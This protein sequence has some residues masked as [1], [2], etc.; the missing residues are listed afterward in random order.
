MTAPSPSPPPPPSIDDGLTSAHLRTIESLLKRAP[1]PTERAMFSAMWSEHCAYVSSRMHLK[2]LPQKGACVI[3]GPGE[4]AGV[5]DIGE[6]LAC[7][8]KIESHNHPSFIEPY[9][10]AA[11]G[12]GGI[13]RD[14]F[15][16][17]ARPVAL[18]NALRFGAPTHPKTRS[19]LKGV[20]QG[21]AGYGNAIGIPTVGGECQFDDGYNHNN[22]VNVMA[23]GIASKK[24]IFYS[25]A[26]QD[27]ARVLYLGAP[28]GSD[29]IH[30]AT[31]ASAEFDDNAQQKRPTVQ[32]GDPFF[33]KRLM[34][35]CL[36][37]MADN[38]ILAIQDMGAAGLTSSISEM[39]D[40]GKSGMDIDLDTI[41]L[42]DA[43]MQ[44]QDIMLS[45]SQERM[46]LIA[47][48]EALDAIAAIAQAYRLPLVPIGHVNK[49]GTLTLRH[50][51]KIV[52]QLPVDALC[53][54][55][56]C[57]DLPQ[58]LVPAPT[59]TQPLP[60]NKTTIADDVRFLV[61]SHHSASRAWLYHQFDRHVGGNTV[62]KHVGTAALIVLPD[63]KRALALTVD[64]NQRY[65][66]LDPKLGAA[67]TVAQAW[68]KLCAI[69][70]D[71]LALT[72]NLN[73]ADPNNPHIMAQLS[74]A[75]DGI[76]LA[77]R[78]LNMPVVS[79]NVSL[80]N[81]TANQPIP[82][83]PIIG[84][85]GVLAS[86][87]TASALECW[88]DGQTIFLFSPNQPQLP[89]S[90]YSLAVHNRHEGPLP[91]LD[92]SLEKKH[93]EF[94]R[95]VVSSDTLACPLTNGGL[96]L[97]LAKMALASGVGFRLNK[98]LCPPDSTHAP[99]A[100]HAF[101]FGEQAAAYLLISSNASTLRKQATQ[102]ALPLIPIGTVGGN[103][104]TAP[105]L[106][107]LELAP[108]KKAYTSWMEDYI[109][110]RNVS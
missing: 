50:H 100:P 44:P 87:Q 60:V 110:R 79:G 34:E 84:A 51:Q 59:H 17:G 102:Q 7:V 26:A 29:G 4:N 2:R 41:P 77:A 70:A 83:T 58:A 66:A 76:A 46:L 55:A 20:A 39:A 104:L 24:Q 109:N 103:R 18:L 14:I 48:P 22:L 54:S 6:G 28:T 96:A 94:V 10:G 1:S 89:A 101:L 91:P 75:I 36:R 78:A 33:G 25:A 62:D 5:I 80:Y 19:L 53:G 23:V 40:K 15:T 37:I 42:R 61:T 63:N 57:Y 107:D 92:L 49:S 8:F 82:P 85:V 88:Q 69:G 99:H 35:A 105:D 38:L 68:R 32:V 108:L 65:C 52:A 16:M 9:Q 71:P 81:Q 3:C 13:L 106:F 45:E 11:T 64:G 73:F 97:A 27:N 86:L 30:G 56:P 74:D 67:H 43:T 93:G 21:I 90:L 31:M 12:V 98:D 47:K 72:N 95:A